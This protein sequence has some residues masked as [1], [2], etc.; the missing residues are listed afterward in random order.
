[1]RERRLRRNRRRFWFK[2]GRTENW[3]VAMKNEVDHEESWKKNFRFSRSQFAN[4]VHELRAWIS[5][6]PMS[7]IFR[8]LTPEIKVAMT[9]YYLKDK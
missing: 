7:P 3:W 5:P 1:M 2:P 9:L 6:V 8:A 4:V